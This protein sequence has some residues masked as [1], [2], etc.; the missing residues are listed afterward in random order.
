MINV[1][2]INCVR[3]NLVTLPN[4][5]DLVRSQ[6]GGGI[7]TPPPYFAK[8]WTKIDVIISYACSISDI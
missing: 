4:L 1:I 5:D 7:P 2:L 3:F 8:Y 6:P